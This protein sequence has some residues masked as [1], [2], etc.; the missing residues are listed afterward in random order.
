[1]T[2]DQMD[3]LHLTIEPDG[4]GAYIVTR[5][6]AVA[7]W[8]E[9]SRKERNLWRAVLT[10]GALHRAYTISALLDWTADNLPPRR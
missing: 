4:E 6:G 10:N 3:A 5:D 9:R 1:M 8:F 7:A 2:P